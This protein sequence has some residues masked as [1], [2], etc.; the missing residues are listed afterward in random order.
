MGYLDE[1]ILMIL[2]YQRGTQNQLEGLRWSEIRNIL[3]REVKPENPNTFNTKVSRSLNRLE[4]RGLITRILKA[5]KEV[6]YTL[7]REKLDE[8]DVVVFPVPLYPDF[9]KGLREATSLIDIN[10]YSPPSFEQ[11]KKSLFEEIEKAVDLKKVYD[12]LMER[13]EKYKSG[14][15]LLADIKDGKLGKPFPS[16]KLDEE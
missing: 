10:P 16:S 6:Y 11:F 12:Q 13:L 8:C 1:T 9:E 5:H 15:L 14:T 4:N 7:N 2:S 3:L